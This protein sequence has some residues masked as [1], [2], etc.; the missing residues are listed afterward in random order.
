MFKHNPS[1]QENTSTQG[2]SPGEVPRQGWACTWI[3]RFFFGWP[4]MNVQPA[5]QPT[6]CA[7]SESW[8][9]LPA[10]EDLDGPAPF[11]TH[12]DRSASFP[13]QVPPEGETRNEAPQKA[14]LPSETRPKGP[15]R[16]KGAGNET[17]HHPTSMGINPGASLRFQK[18]KR[19]HR[20]PAHHTAIS[21]LIAGW[22]S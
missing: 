7:C 19:K 3:T 16:W 22:G 20:L 5:R 12:P 11:F 9:A 14:H 8:H 6:T 2:A 21:A 18:A 13:P 15:P 1:A 17:D 10:P 4:A